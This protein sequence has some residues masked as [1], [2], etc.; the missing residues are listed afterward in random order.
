[1]TPDAMFSTPIPPDVLGDARDTVTFDNV[2]EPAFRTLGSPAARVIPDRI[3]DPV[4][5]TSK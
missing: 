3:R 2:A 5:A 4:A 1:M